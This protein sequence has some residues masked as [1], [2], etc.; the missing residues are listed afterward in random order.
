M[1]DLKVGVK[2]DPVLILCP[3]ITGSCITLLRLYEE[4]RVLGGNERRSTIRLYL[5]ST[6][7]VIKWN[8]APNDGNNFQRLHLVLILKL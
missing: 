1:R 3:S 7:K 2:L 6:F 8:Y 5:S 4:F